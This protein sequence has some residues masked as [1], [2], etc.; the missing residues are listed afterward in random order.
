M[1]KHILN[2]EFL[3]TDILLIIQYMIDDVVSMNRL[4][5]VYQNRYRN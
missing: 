3:C 5:T 1:P 2:T 4:A